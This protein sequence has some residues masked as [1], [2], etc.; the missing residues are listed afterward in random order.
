MKIT[1]VPFAVLRFQYQLARV[2]LQLIEDQVVAKMDG[3]SP[4]R[5]LYERSVGRLDMAVGT[6]LGA[7]EVERRGAA[8][9]ERSEALRR[10]TTLDTAADRAVEQAGADVQDAVDAAAAVRQEARADKEDEVNR[11][12]ANAAHQKV[13]AVQDAE[14][15]VAKATKQADK[16]AA[17]R[18][19]AVGA[20][21]GQKHDKIRAAER[22]AEAVADAKAKDAQK[23]RSDAAAKRGQAARVEQMADAKKHQRKQG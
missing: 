11:A 9:I 14:K 12:R 20:A 5:L 3:E 13:A 10:A 6:A 17:Q 15:R 8:L 22:S 4:A 1:D 18:K 7:P 16:V 21:K 2:P 23:K 19:D